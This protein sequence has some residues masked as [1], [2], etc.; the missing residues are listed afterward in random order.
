MPQEAAGG[1][2]LVERV[3]AGVVGDDRAVLRRAEVV[4]PRAR[5]VGAGDDVFLG[6]V[7]EVT[8]LH[9]AASR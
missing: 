8:V 6:V 2:A 3:A 7:V 5:G 1:G 9:G 4:G